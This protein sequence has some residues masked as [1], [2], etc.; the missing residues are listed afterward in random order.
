M[1]GQVF[2]LAGNPVPDGSYAV[3]LQDPEYLAWVGGARNYGPSG[4][5]IY[6][7]NKPKVATFRIQLLSPAG[8]PVSEVIEVQTWASCTQNLVIVNFVQNH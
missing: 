6:L 8:T 7:D 5:E 1:A 4:W 2:D 3:K